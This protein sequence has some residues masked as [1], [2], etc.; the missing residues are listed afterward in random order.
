MRIERKAAKFMV[1]LADALA[2]V[3]SENVGYGEFHV[4][5]V[6]IMFDGE[7]TEYSLEFDGHG[8]VWI[9]AGES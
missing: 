1:R 7:S 5:R 8:I 6:P 2:E 4:D 3:Q 9:T